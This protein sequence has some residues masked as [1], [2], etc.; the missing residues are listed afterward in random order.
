MSQPQ[1]IQRAGFLSSSV[2]RDGVLHSISL[3]GGFQEMVSVEE[4]NS[5]PLL[6]NSTAFPYN[7]FTASDDHWS[8]GRRRVGMLVNVLEENKFY[9]LIPVGFFGNAGN[10]GEAEWL[11]LSEWERALRID[12][13]GSYTLQAPTPGNNFTSIVKTASDIGITADANSCWVELEIRRKGDPIDGHIIPDANETYD[14]GS[15]DKKFRDLYLSGNTLYMG[16][17]PLS[18]VNGQLTLNGT[19]VTGSTDTYNSSVTSSS[20]PPSNFTIL[21]KQRILLENNA[22]S[23][24]ILSTLCGIISPGGDKVIFLSETG[25]K[26]YSIET[27]YDTDSTHFNNGFLEFK[28]ESEFTANYF[29][30]FYGQSNATVKWIDQNHIIIGSLFFKY[31]NNE[32][33]FKFE[34]KTQAEG[35]YSLATPSNFGDARSVSVSKTNLGTSILISR[36]VNNVWQNDLYYYN[37][38]QP[39]TGVYGII[40]GWPIDHTF[41]NAN[42]SAISPDGSAVAF[43]NQ[44]TGNYEIHRWNGSSWALAYT[45]TASTTPGVRGVFSS[46]VNNVHT[47]SYAITANNGPIQNQN[48]IKFVEWDP[49]NNIYQDKGII[50][51]TM[52]GNVFNMDGSGNR[53]VR[54]T[55]NP[56]SWDIWEYDNSTTTWTQVTD[57]MGSTSNIGFSAS[58]TLDKLITVEDPLIAGTS[59]AFI[60]YDTSNPASFP[61][62]L[63]VTRASGTPPTSSTGYTN[64]VIDLSTWK[65]GHGY[66]LQFDGTLAFQ[67]MQKCTVWIDDLNWIECL[68]SNTAMTTNINGDPATALR[69]R[70]L[71]KQGNRLSY[72]Y[73][74]TQ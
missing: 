55:F 26:V 51:N 72:N 63:P 68:V 15:P 67:K 64:K 38:P 61:S 49:I 42:W 23:P 60:I 41:T 52:P 13:T 1:G 74:I 14:L 48:Q 59:P 53:V 29:S 11:A 54:H 4:R 22:Y 71:R 5:I 8:S 27:P 47:A 45:D 17:Q 36:K 24:P 33:S 2:S 62:R 56:V 6:E 58:S 3:K 57:T 19:P 32:W 70:I 34:F 25:F 66:Y 28:L 43:T 30:G 44:L 12:P 35:V 20:T 16:G 18:I 9:Q 39:W 7:G 31:E 10:L 21:A 37:H 50:E 69:L 46:S 40:S 73:H 65:V